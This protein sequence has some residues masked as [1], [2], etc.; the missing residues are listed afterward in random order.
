MYAVGPNLK[1]QRAQRAAGERREKLLTAKSA[2]KDCK[3][4][5]EEITRRNT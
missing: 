2:K 5:E 4:R 3:G 1:T